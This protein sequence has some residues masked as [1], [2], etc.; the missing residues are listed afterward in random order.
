[1]VFDIT[2]QQWNIKGI[3]QMV[4]RVGIK[5]CMLFLKQKTKKQAKFHQ[6]MNFPVQSPQ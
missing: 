3:F 4:S 2:I 6:V 5:N 1:M